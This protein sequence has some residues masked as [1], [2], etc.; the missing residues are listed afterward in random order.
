[1]Q[2]RVAPPIFVVAES[3]VLAFPTID[4]A[5]SYMEPVDVRNG[6][7]KEVYDRVGRRLRIVIERRRAARWLLFGS[8]EVCKLVAE[9]GRPEG[10][11]LA[12]ELRHY[13]RTLGEDATR[14]ELLPLET[15]VEKTLAAAHVRRY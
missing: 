5:A 7:Y 8:V 1:M 9:E 13:L 4:E 14:L 2:A 11:Q 3:E 12:S 15:L 10:F 6:E